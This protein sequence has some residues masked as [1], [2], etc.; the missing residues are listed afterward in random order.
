VELVFWTFLLWLIIVLLKKPGTLKKL[1][2]AKVIDREMVSP[3]GFQW[4]NPDL[5]AR[6]PPEPSVELDLFLFFTFHI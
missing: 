1:K 5:Y 2:C 4:K 6:L 3:T